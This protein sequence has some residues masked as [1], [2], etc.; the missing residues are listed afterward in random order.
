M[1]L[2]QLEMFKTVAE[3]GGFTRASE[4]L[5]VSHSAISRQI[6]LLE[7]ELGRSLFIRANK[8]V[9]LTPEGRE[10]LPR[11]DTIFREIADAIQCV[12]QVGSRRRLR[13]G[14]GTTMLSLFLPPILAQFK[15]Q[16]ANANLVITTGHTPA[17]LH[18]LRARELDLAIVSLPCD[19]HGFSVTPL[20]REEIVLAIPN[21]HA[22]STRRSLHINELVGL[23]LIVFSKDSS[24]RTILDHFFHEIGIAPSI[25]LEVENDE[26][27]ERAVAGGIGFCFLPRA[28]A[29]QDHVHSLRIEGHPIYRDV[30]LVSSPPVNGLAADFLAICRAHVAPMAAAANR[31]GY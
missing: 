10:L 11:V 3:M 20:Y 16:H 9:A 24:T 27:A 30:A 2:R 13:I 18:S 15:Q 22:F 31:S 14:T 4:K 25:C 29:R 21:R 8:R 7:E 1:D 12:T 28:R 23:P 17:I 6:K 26:A 19:A 5:H